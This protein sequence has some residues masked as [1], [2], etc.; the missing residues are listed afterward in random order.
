MTDNS[1]VVHN[2]LRLSGPGLT[3]EEIDS[4]N[5]VGRLDAWIKGNQ[6]IGTICYH[7]LDTMH[8]LTATPRCFSV[9][10][11][12]QAYKLPIL[13]SPAVDQFSKSHAEVLHDGGR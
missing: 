13:R 5:E 8:T 4:I 10:P 3:A 7:N 9:P 6:R 12:M 11:R 1:K 2:S